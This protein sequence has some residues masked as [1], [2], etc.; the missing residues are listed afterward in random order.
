M[1]TARNALSAIGLADGRVLVVGGSLVDAGN[2]IYDPASDS[3]SRAAASPSG[4]HPAGPAL[5]AL[6][7]GRVLALNSYNFASD[8]E[9]YDPASDRWTPL[10]S[11]LLWDGV[12]ATPLADG[13]VLVMSYGWFREFDLIYDPATDSFQEV[14]LRPWR[15]NDSTVTLLADGRV[16]VQGAHYSLDYYP[17]G[18][19]STLIYDPTADRWTP[20][21][22][23]REARIENTATLLASGL[24]LF[25]GGV[26]TSPYPTTSVELYDPRDAELDQALYLPAANGPPW[27]TPAPWPTAWPIPTPWSGEPSGA[28]GPPGE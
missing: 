8:G 7:D 22:P 18:S 13:R 4:P 2:E 5:T 12:R 17:A 9:I 26:T 21:R 10:S 25:V 1:R 3:W 11:R 15:F 14:A 27:P 20:A 28:A 6:S 16:L 19:A 23:L 24:L